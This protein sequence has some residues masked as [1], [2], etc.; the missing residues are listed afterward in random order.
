MVWGMDSWDG[1]RLSALAEKACLAAA[2]QVLGEVVQQQESQ[3]FWVQAQ[4]RLTL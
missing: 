3:Y 4:P 2:Q 1:R